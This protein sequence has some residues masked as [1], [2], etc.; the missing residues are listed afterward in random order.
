M[1]PR[2]M[3]AAGRPGQSCRDFRRSCLVV[4]PQQGLSNN[5]T[6]CQNH[7]AKYDNTDSGL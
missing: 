3:E 6:L 2:E 7:W 5:G 4:L 1:K